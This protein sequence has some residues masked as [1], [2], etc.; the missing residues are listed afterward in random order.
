MDEFFLQHIVFV[1]DM[2]AL[3]K[4]LRVRDDALLEDLRAFTAQMQ[5]I[6]RPK[7]FYRVSFIEQRAA[8]HLLIDA[9]KLNSRVL[10]VN[11][12]E[13]HRVFPFLATCGVELAEFRAQ[14]SDIL[15]EFWADAIM[16]AALQAA[17]QAFTTDLNARFGVGKLASMNPGSLPD[18]PITQQAPF[19]ELLGP[20]ARQTGV[21]LTE[22]MLMQPAKSVSGLYFE[23]E[24]GFV[25]CQL[26]PRVS[27]PNRRAE[28]DAGL[29]EQKYRAV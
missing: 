7:V 5:E 11:L 16:E 10:C 9:V 27:C 14:E 4:R 2:A 25:N 29:R 1:P 28:F 18:W 12:G 21:T 8:D 3:T 15:R 19:F 6:A 23:T 13:V 22:S 17:V 20:G 26:C 24:T